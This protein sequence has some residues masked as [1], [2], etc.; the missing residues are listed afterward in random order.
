MYFPHHFPFMLKKKNPKTKT[1]D[2]HKPKPL[3]TEVLLKVKSLH[4]GLLIFFMTSKFCI[5]EI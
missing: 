3:Y 2:P 1:E 4:T 5:I